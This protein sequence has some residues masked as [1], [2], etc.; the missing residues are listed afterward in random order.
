MTNPKD[1]KKKMDETLERVLLCRN[2]RVDGT[3]GVRSGLVYCPMDHK[4]RLVHQSVASHNIAFMVKEYQVT[5]LDC[6]E[7]LTKAVHPICMNE[8]GV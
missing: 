1:V 6:S 5:G 3:Y 7:M 2:S 8:F 4:R